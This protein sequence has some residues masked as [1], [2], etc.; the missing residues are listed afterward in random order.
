VRKIRL[1]ASKDPWTVMTPESMQMRN[2]FGGNVGNLVYGHAA[3]RTLTTST[4]Q[5]EA[6]GY[7]ATADET[8]LINENYD[9]FV[10]PLANAF[11]TSF[12]PELIRLTRM[13]N[14]LKVPV[15]VLGVGA[16]TTTTGDFDRLAP[17]SKVVGKFVSAVLDRSAT[18]GVRG[19]VTADYLNS[20]GF[21]DVEVIGCPSMYLWGQDLP[22]PRIP[23]TID[24]TSKVTVTVSPYVVPMGPI[25]EH[26]LDTY[27]LLDYVAQDRTTLERMLWGPRRTDR[28]R[29]SDRPIYL[30]HRLFRE[31]RARIF[32]DPWTW[33]DHLRTRDVVF[34]SRI[35]GTI[36]AVVSG[37]PAVLLAHDSRTLELAEYHE[38]PYRLINEVPPDVDV[39]DLYA[40]ADFGPMITN[41]KARFEDYLGFLARNGLDTVFAAG[42]SPDDFDARVAAAKFPGAVGAPPPGS[43]VLQKRLRWL[44]DSTEAGEVLPVKPDRKTQHRKPKTEPTSVPDPSANPTSRLTAVAK[45]A[46]GSLRGRR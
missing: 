18:I 10:L 11:R 14:K 25:V 39:R 44:Y 42:E 30:S 6:N 17:L 16:Q 22:T 43:E 29:T 3:H 15:V 5:V 45:S 19:E 21:R 28:K 32:V 24:S 2:V 40:E 4:T 31:Q 12:V 7:A 35:H 13:I 1:R 27:P 38:I 26:H 9:V 46:R 37:T 20:L 8:R 33:F 41:H 36:S 23:T 34:G